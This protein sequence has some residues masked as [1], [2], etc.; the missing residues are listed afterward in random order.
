MAEININASIVDQQVLG[1]INN[2]PN[3]FS[4]LN[5]LNKKKASAFVLLCIKTFLN[6]STEEAFEFFTDGGNDCGVDGIEIGDEEDGEFTV[7]IFQGKYKVEDLSG[8][9]NFPE[10]GVKNAILTVNLL[11]DPNKEFTMNENIRPKIEEIRSM[12][13]DGLIP[14][15][16]FVL[17]NNGSK[18]NDVAQEQIKNAHI[19]EEQVRFIYYNQDD[20]VEVLRARKKI[21]DNIQMAGKIIIE[22]FNYCR[23]L[24]GKISV[25]QIADL[26]DYH[27][28]VILDRNI[29]RYLGLHSNRVNS[30]ISETLKNEERRENF[31]FFNN[32]IT[33]ICDK[34]RYNAL[35]GE[36][37]NIR[38]EGLQ[39]INGGQTCKTI[40][41]T[42]AEQPTLREKLC[43][44]F[45]LLR[46]YE[47]DEKAENFVNDI[48][49]ATNS[50]NPVD[51]RDLHANDEIQQ[52]MGIGIR[53]LGYVY[54]RKREDSPS[55][56]NLIHSSIVAE[57]VLAIWRQKPHQA[58]FMRKEHF[59][60]LYSTIFDNLNGA[61]ALLAVFIF[62][63]VENERKRPTLCQYHF[64]PYSA[65][66]VAMRIGVLFLLNSKIK[67]DQLTHRNFTKMSRIFEEQ[68]EELYRA[69]TK[70]VDDALKE[71]YGDR[72]LSLQQLSAT[73]R[74]G[75]LIDK[76]LEP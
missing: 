24:I 15:V 12:I 50:Q 65:H 36:N 42:L 35:Q 37:F 31:Y 30:A 69:A 5:D 67:L 4:S 52:T 43:N 56:S 33:A 53:E 71:F 44:T 38:I 57:S 63:F 68:K 21:N 17:C 60:R 1:L 26:F 75:D 27:D 74:R 76:L 49:Y 58:K 41:K 18:W 59:G 62:R 8:T 40:Q 51:L 46:L 64:L 29:R 73:F 55:S 23:V 72:E 39:I 28:D 11:F 47:L 48:T 20:I 13:R 25:A 61:Q 34:F 7:T 19:P 3:L 22:E 54:K 14:N 45:V 70:K 6:K 2:Y 32:G 9:A 10:N 66:Y 16:R